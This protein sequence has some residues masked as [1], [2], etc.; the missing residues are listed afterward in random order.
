MV[1]RLGL[2]A[3]IVV[4]A[5]LVWQPAQAAV[6]ESAVIKPRDLTAHATHD[7]VHLT[8][9]AGVS[10][11]AYNV[12][13]HTD[14]EYWNY[15]GFFLWPSREFVVGPDVPYELTIAELDPDSSYVIE[16]Y[17]GD[18]RD[19]DSAVVYVH[20]EPVPEHWW[21]ANIARGI[22]TGVFGDRILVYW[23]CLSQPLIDELEVEVKEYGAPQST[24]RTRSVAC[25]TDVM[26]SAPLQRGAAYQVAIQPI[27]M[28]HYQ[29]KLVATIPS[30]VDESRALENGIPA[31]DVSVEYSDEVRGWV[32][33]VSV[34][35]DDL[36]SLVE[37]EWIRD[38]HRM[39]RV[40][41]GPFVYYSDSPGPFPF[42]VRRVAHQAASSQWSS[43][44]LAGAEARPPWANGV[45]YQQRGSELHIVWTPGWHPSGLDGYRAYLVG[46]GAPPQ[47]VDTGL[48]RSAVFELAP[49]LSQHVLLVGAYR[50][51][52]G[53]GELTRVDIDLARQPE[54][55]LQVDKYQP[56]CL[57]STG[58]PMRGFWTVNHGVPPYR[59]TVGAQEPVTSMLPHGVFEAGCTADDGQWSD[60][61]VPVAQVSVGAEDG[62]GRRMN[63]SLA[64]RVS[65]YG[66]PGAAPVTTINGPRPVGLRVNEPIVGSTGFGV[67]VQDRSLDAQYWRWRF[68]IRWR[69][70]GQQDW[71][72]ERDSVEVALTRVGTIRLKGLMPDTSYE[73]QVA[74]DFPGI[75]AEEIPEEAWSRLQ[76]VRTW[77]SDIRPHYSRVGTSV[78]V[79]WDAGPS[80]WGYSVALRGDGESWWK[81]HVPSGTD[82]ES[83]V[84]R[85]IPVDAVIEVEVMTPPV[86]APSW[87]G[88]R[89]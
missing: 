17:H 1:H 47:V 67:V 69:L 55:L 60:N 6:P 66:E 9:A 83:V 41:A 78:T 59:V 26:V 19:R 8:W 18:W 2:S 4:V 61:G 62:R 24:A 57:L 85:G 20:T 84:F 15:S 58:S 72:Y 81:A 32:F 21:E 88:Y 35:D 25:A 31:W 5:L 70:P 56:S 89:G 38:G 52:L 37:V 51:D 42:R 86:G 33:A 76:E 64:Y 53:L 40:G 77:P 10:D 63:G 30:S 80:E 22:A 34:D 79:T 27:D 13:L 49:H 48:S 44:R 43:S 12:R 28:E 74:G 36:T 46:Y 82:M 29:K 65:G 54:L 39:T 11:L 14:Y 16:V 73:F 50:T 87:D 68:V 45:R 7:T 3:W 71:N 23:N 75:R